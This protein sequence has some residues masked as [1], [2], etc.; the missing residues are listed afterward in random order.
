MYL[1]TH[2]HGLPKEDTHKSIEQKNVKHKFPFNSFKN[3]EDQED[4][5]LDHQ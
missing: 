5:I 2:V 3:Y 4:K 1:I